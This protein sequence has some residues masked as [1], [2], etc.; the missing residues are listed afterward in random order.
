MQ[1]ELKKLTIK[2]YKS[3][4]FKSG[5]LVGEFAVMFNPTTFTQKYDLEYEEQQGQGTAGTNQKFV[6]IKPQEYTFEF[7][8]DGTGAAAPAP[9][10]GIAALIRSFVSLT[11]EINGDTHR[12]NFLELS[13]GAFV[14]KCVLKSA[15]IAYSLF[16]PSGAPL[17]AKITAT[18]SDSVDDKLRIANE[19]RNSPDLTHVRRFEAGDT[20]PLMVY[21]IYEDPH[22][23]SRVARANDLDN[24]RAVEPGTKLTLKPLEKLLA[25]T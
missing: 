7:L 25:D 5:D 18:F 10:E 17:R 2:A 14:F 11:A 8:L 15:S 9:P 1:G 24:F 4:E 3:V 21:R 23:Y 20:V 12:P 16:E 13:W 22:L 6:K 19:G